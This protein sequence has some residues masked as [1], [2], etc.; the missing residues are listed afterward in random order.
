MADDGGVCDGCGLVVES[1]AELETTHGR[2]LCADCRREPQLEPAPRLPGLATAGSRRPF[3]SPRTP[4]LVAAIAF[5]LLALANVGSIL[6]KRGTIAFLDSLKPG[7]A[8]A[9]V[10]ATEVDDR[11]RTMLHTETAINVLAVAVFLFWFH[12][13]AANVE[14]YGLQRRFSPGW[15]VASFFIPFLNLV[16]PLGVALETWRGSACIAGRVDVATWR[17]A[18]PSPLLVPWWIAYVVG[19]AWAAIAARNLGRARS[20]G[21][22]DDALHS[23]IEGDVLQIVAAI[24]CILVVREITRL[25]EAGHRS[26]ERLAETFA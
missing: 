21:E 17:D 3:R 12:R 22:L 15:A 1:S 14:A 2:R 8:T 18:R 26:P 16:R 5:A 6:A 11:Q 24:L 20:V 7:D 13:T 25:Q 4:A 19:S 9:R 10:R 23:S